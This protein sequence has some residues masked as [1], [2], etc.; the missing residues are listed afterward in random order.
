MA[1]YVPLLEYA[2]PWSPRGTEVL[3]VT[4]KFLQAPGG[5]EM[6]NYVFGYGSLLERASRMRTNPDAIGA[7]PARLTGYSRGWYH[8]FA[9]Y[10]GSTCTTCSFMVRDL[11]T[12]RRCRR[13]VR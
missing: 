1:F 11:A 13:V 10:V 3:A 4:D 7:W 6:T 2:Q 8:Q 9:N 12:V 5:Y